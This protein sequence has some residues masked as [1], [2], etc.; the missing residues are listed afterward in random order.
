MTLRK[1]KNISGHGSLWEKDNE[2]NVFTAANRD[3]VLKGYR[4]KDTL[5]IWAWI[6][7]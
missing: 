3:T 7:I 2:S 5:N 1:K 6:Y 4:Q